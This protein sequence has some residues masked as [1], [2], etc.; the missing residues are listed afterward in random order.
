MQAYE[1][2]GESVSTIYATLASVFPYIETWCLQSG[3]RPSS[4]DANRSCMT[5]PSFGGGWGRSLIGSALAQVWR[6]TDLEGF[7]ARYVGRSILAD[8]VVANAPH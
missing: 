4:P 8:A 5:W 6:V 2:D 1:I 3:D 7:F